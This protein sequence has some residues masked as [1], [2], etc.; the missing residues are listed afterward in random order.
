MLQRLPLGKTGLQV[1]VAGLGAGGRAGS[2][3]H[4]ER[5]K[6]R[7]RGQESPACS[8][9]KNYAAEILPALSPKMRLRLSGFLGIRISDLSGTSGVANEGYVGLTPGGMDLMATANAI[10]LSSAGMTDTIRW[11]VLD[12]AASERLGRR[13]TAGALSEPGQNG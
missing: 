13:R 6:T 12:R 4:A 2:A 8:R 5:A 3:S 1:G 9:A 11:L 7:G 10:R